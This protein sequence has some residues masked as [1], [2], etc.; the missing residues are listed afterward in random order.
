MKRLKTTLIAVAILAI[1]VGGG[2]GL[3]YLQ[4]PEPLTVQSATTASPQPTTK[5]KQAEVKPPVPLTTA[6][7]TRLTN[8]ERAKAGLPPVTENALLNASAQAKAQDMANRNYWSHDT[9]DGIEPWSFITAQGYSYSTAGENLACG[10]KDDSAEVIV[11]W[12]NSPTHKENI[13]NPK[14]SEVGFGI[15]ETPNYTCGNFPQSKRT[16][17]V[18]HFATPY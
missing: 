5:F 1:G 16:I 14:Y 2:F 10:F 9:P 15:L 13:V 17:I 3:A 12:M 11:G 18:Q 8:E 6:N 7:L 4:A